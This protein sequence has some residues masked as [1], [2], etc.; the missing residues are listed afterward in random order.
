M[1]FSNADV[2][3]LGCLYEKE[4]GM[5]WYIKWG[6]ERFELGYCFDYAYLFII[7]KLFHGT[8]PKMDYLYLEA[9]FYFF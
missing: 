6:G 8:S 5:E 2:I 1:L 4:Y 9:L 3:W 7:Q